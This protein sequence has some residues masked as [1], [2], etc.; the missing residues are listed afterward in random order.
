L[1][2]AAFLGP[3]FLATFFAGRLAADFLETFLA[4]FFTPFFP[5]APVAFFAAFFVGTFFLGDDFF[6]EGVDFLPV[7]MM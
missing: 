7:A 5:E 3:D 6:F 4:V 1:D 2:F